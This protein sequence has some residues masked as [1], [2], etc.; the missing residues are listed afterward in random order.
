MHY[1]IKNKSAL[2][3]C[4]H[5]FVPRC[6][7][8][9]VRIANE[10]QIFKPKE[11]LT[12]NLLVF[13]L[14]LRSRTILIPTQKDLSFMVRSISGDSRVQKGKGRVLPMGERHGTEAGH[15]HSHTCYLMRTSS[16]EPVGPSACG[17]PLVTSFSSDRKTSTFWNPHGLTHCGESWGLIS[18]GAQN[19]LKHTIS[20]CNENVLTDH[21]YLWLFKQSM[22]SIT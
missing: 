2:V 4:I 7:W 6:S 8:K 11:N 12:E 5:V 16:H 3:L 9:R 21:S 13:T 18:S 10:F 14:H 1:T 20:R 15:T 22:L 17:C 19:F